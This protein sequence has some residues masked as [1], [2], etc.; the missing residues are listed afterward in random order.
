V[1]SLERDLLTIFK[2]Q[3]YTPNYF[4]YSHI[5]E[6]LQ[7]GVLA[8]TN[9]SVAGLAG[10]LR[11]TA[12]VANEAELNSSGY[13]LLGRGLIQEALTIF[14]I[15]ALL[16]PQSSNSF[17]S[18]GEGYERISNIPRAIQAYTKALELDSKNAHALARLIKLKSL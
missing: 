5:H 12:P 15:N 4:S 1:E 18:I 8:D 11:R 7:T 9:A 17:D 2:Q 14:R 10:Q 3:P 13:L 16:F 6:W